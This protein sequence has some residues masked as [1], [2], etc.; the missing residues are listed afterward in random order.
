MQEMGDIN[1]YDVYADVCYPPRARAGGEQLLRALHNAP[2]PLPGGMRTAAHD[3]RAAGAGV[4]RGED[5]QARGA[6]ELAGD[7]PTSTRRAR[8]QLRGRSS[9]A[10]PVACRFSCMTPCQA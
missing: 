5:E 3:S 10:L 9:G 6:D 2:A 1:I 4:V 8:E 7:V